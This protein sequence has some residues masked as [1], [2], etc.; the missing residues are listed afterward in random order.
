MG[1]LLVQDVAAETGSG[2]RRLSAAAPQVV[3]QFVRRDGEQVRLQ[4]A[5]IVEVRQAVEE[6]DERFL[7][8]ILAGG[9]IMQTHGASAGSS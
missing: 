1:Y 7:N 5:A 2:L 4:V 9:P 3:R 6:A 8:H